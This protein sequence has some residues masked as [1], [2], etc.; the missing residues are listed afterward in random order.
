MSYAGDIVEQYICMREGH[1]GVVCA[2]VHTC[3]QL[4]W[5]SIKTKT[6]NTDLADSIVTD[7]RRALLPHAVSS[8]HYIIRTMLYITLH[9]AFQ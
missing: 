7:N 5:M 4:H 8:N 6:A 9:I 3:A 1:F 2:G